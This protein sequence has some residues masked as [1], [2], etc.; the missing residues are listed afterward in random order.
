MHQGFLM[1]E[2]SLALTLT[3][4]LLE[5]VTVQYYSHLFE[6]KLHWPKLDLL[7]SKH[8][9]DCTVREIDHWSAHP[10]FLCTSVFLVCFLI[11]Q[12]WAQNSGQWR[13]AIRSLHLRVTNSVGSLQWRLTNNPVTPKAEKQQIYL[14]PVE[15][16]WKKANQSS[17]SWREP[18]GSQ[19]FGAFIINLFFIVYLKA[20]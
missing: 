16:S 15:A 10:L 5:S 20:D 19:V 7:R 14:P 8:G 12:R 6:S 2:A 3:N 4:L 18:T 9:E 1:C 13:D 17:E 11:R